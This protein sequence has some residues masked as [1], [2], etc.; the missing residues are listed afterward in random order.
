MYR[1]GVTGSGIWDVGQST[2]MSTGVSPSAALRASLD[3]LVERVESISFDLPSAEQPKRETLRNDLAWT[4]REYLLPRL[5]D[6]ESPLLAVVIG[7]TGSGKSTL[8][9]SL[10]Q[11]RISDPGAIRPT[12]RVPVIWTHPDHADRYEEGFLTGYGTAVTATHRLRIVTSNH[13]LLDGVTVLD[14]PD[15]DSVVEG[16]R[17]MVDDLLAVADLTVFVTS[18]QRYADA[19]PWEFLERARRR[20]LPI[21][22]VLNRLPP[23]GAD[24]VVED[25]RRRL[26]EG[27]IL[28]QADAQTI[29]RIPE[30]PIRTEHGGLPSESVASLRSALEAMSDPERRRRVVISATQGSV[31]DAVDRALALAIEIEGEVGQ[32]GALRL[33]ARHAYQAQAGEIAESLRGGTL[34]RGEVLRRWQDFLGTGELLKVLTEG[35]GRVRRWATKVFGGTRKV[36]E[37]NDEA[38]DEIVAAVVRRAD[39]AAGGTAAAWELDGAGRVLLASTDRRLWH[40]DP[41]T[42]QRARTAIEDW[43]ATLSE[44]IAEQGAGKRRWAQVASFGV[45]ATALVVLLAV[46]AQTGGITGAEF[47]VAAGAAAAQQKILEHFFGGAAARSLIEE[48]RGQLVAALAGVLDEDE[49]RFVEILDAYAGRE[50]WADELRRGAADVRAR[51]GE[52][53]GR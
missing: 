23:E 34:I 17:E 49:R 52:F 19:V 44:L 21:L 9:N 31:Q 25:Y 10:A 1:E 38:G 30:Q 50:S 45:N 39:L 32:V 14:A 53:Y 7:S 48:A 2:R 35:A 12:T 43:I 24:D 27:G 3:G 29:L 47:G 37:I 40:H 11:Q 15:F 6:L 8:V 41:E 26:S 22:F 36:E 16:H 46:F 42:P 20:R 13:D 28:S 51:A 18:A 5:S 33:A 4:I